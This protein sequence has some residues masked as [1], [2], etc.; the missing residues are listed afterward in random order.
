MTDNFRTRK[1]LVEQFLILSIRQFPSSK[2]RAFFPLWSR[3]E[4]IR[5]PEIPQT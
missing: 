1:L 3:Y 4:S 5:H 2:A